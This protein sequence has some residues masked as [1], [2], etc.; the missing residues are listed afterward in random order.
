MDPMLGMVFMV[1]WNWAPYNYQLCQGQTLMLNQ[2]EALYSLMGTVF[3]G[4]GSTNFNLPNLQGRAPI[5]TGILNSVYYTLGNSGGSQATTLSF[6]NL[7]AHT[8]AASFTP[9]GSGGG[10]GT[11]TGAVTL[12]FSAAT[13]LSST[14]T[15]TV[16]LANTVGGGNN[17]PVAGNVLTSA[18]TGAKVYGAASAGDFALGGDQTFTGTATGTV[19]GNA[20]GNVTLAV[21]GGG[22]GGTVSIGVTGTNTPFTNMQPY[23]AMSFIIAVNGLYPDRP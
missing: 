16:K 23:L 13:T 19:T 4:N 1:P 18:G 5:G 6:P 8:H 7:P 3:G 14:V 21:S 9:G 2:Y 15:G 17:V 10:G 20:T 12:P 11:A 22:G